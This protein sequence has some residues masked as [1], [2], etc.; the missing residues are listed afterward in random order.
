MPGNKRTVR[1]LKQ[2]HSLLYKYMF[3]KGQM[4][5]ESLIQPSVRDMPRREKIRKDREDGKL[6]RLSDCH[7]QTPYPEI[8]TLPWS[9]HKKLTVDHQRKSQ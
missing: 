6:V 8:W 7:I 4:N 5:T 2:A 1:V 9:R 3:V